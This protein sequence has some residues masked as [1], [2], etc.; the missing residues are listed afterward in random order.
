MLGEYE[1]PATK[2]TPHMIPQYDTGISFSASQAAIKKG[3]RAL[4]DAQ[5]NGARFAQ[6]SVMLICPS[7]GE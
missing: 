5:C 3:I 7:W 1:A 2:G 6:F 4:A